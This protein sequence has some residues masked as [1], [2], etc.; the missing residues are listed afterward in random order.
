MFFYNSPYTGTR[1]A[2]L[3][4]QHMQLLLKSGKVIYIFS[5]R[6]NLL[7]DGSPSQVGDYQMSEACHTPVTLKA[8]GVSPVE[9]V[10]Y[11]FGVNALLYQLRTGC[12]WDMIPEGFRTQ[13]FILIIVKLMR[14]NFTNAVNFHRR[15]IGKFSH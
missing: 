11:Q 7:L 8:L 4:L 13:R 10:A 6:D 12:R 5:I 14:S 1:R 3:F 15:P 9:Q 2:H